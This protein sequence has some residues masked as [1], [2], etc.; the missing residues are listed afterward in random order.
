MELKGLLEERLRDL[1]LG[2]SVSGLRDSLLCLES[3]AGCGCA[4]GAIGGQ[5]CWQD[6]E[7]GQ[8]GAVPPH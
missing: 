3:W 6:V 7:G 8:A 5:H 2:D 4:G 1:E